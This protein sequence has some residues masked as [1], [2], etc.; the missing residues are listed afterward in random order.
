MN[1]LPK[2]S[3]T[4]PLTVT[5]LQSGMAEIATG[6]MGELH[7]WT[8]QFHC[9]GAGGSSERQDGKGGYP[10]RRQA[11]GSVAVRWLRMRVLAGL[12]LVM[13]GGGVLVQG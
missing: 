5:R 4:F 12:G 8:G 10:E 6:V 9:A 13:I 7:A 3:A 1:L 2:T 11:T